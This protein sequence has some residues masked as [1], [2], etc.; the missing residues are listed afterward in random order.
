MLTSRALPEKNIQT[1]YKPV[2]VPAAAAAIALNLN[3]AT[4]ATANELYNRIVLKP[5][6][7]SNARATSAATAIGWAAP[8]AQLRQI[9]SRLYEL[10]AVANEDE[11]PWSDASELALRSFL[12]AY[13]QPSRPMITLL[14]NGNLRAIWK[15][16]RERH[17][18]LQFLGGD[19]VQYVMISRRP[20]A[21][22]GSQS[23]GRD[24]VLGVIAQL[25]GMRLLELVA[26]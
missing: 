3:V 21:G 24:S 8:T 26:G 1:T 15:D 4:P 23:S 22:F 19:L 12:N 18:G 9:D 11:I 16:G 10:R 2:R 20:G 6:A 7:D 14:D 25:H 13:R 5:I 17:V